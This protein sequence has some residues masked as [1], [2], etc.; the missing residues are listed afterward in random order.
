MKKSST[1]DWK[2]TLLKLKFQV[3]IQS[4]GIHRESFIHIHHVLFS[5]ISTFKLPKQTNK[6]KPLRTNILKRKQLNYQIQN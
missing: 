3:R 2:T 6:Q 4:N 1:V 5:F